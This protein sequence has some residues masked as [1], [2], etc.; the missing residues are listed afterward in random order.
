MCFKFFKKSN[1]A[2]VEKLLE[3]QAKV[4]FSVHLLDHCSMI[5]FVDDV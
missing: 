4:L 3:G 2:Q 1:F 5:C